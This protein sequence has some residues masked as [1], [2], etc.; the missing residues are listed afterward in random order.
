[1]PEWRTAFE[2]IEIGKGRKIKGGTDIAILSYGHPGNFALTAARTLRTEGIE[3][4][5]YDMRFVKPLD[6]ILLHDV[7]REFDKII[8]VEDG[9]IQ[10]GFGSAITEFMVTHGYN[11]QTRILGI[12]DDII[13]HGTLKE[14]HHEAGID[15]EGIA[16]AARELLKE[17]LTTKI[18]S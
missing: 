9:T 12:P 2:Q 16:E 15:A 3:A 7:F 14:L 10:G 8:T 11:A 17:K 6:E 4:A 5:V 18:L 1:M 13:E